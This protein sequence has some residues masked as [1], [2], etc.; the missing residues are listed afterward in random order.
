MGKQK[1][2]ASKAEIAARVAQIRA[3][4]DRDRVAHLGQTPRSGQPAPFSG[5][6][7]SRRS[8]HR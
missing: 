6:I 5:Q 3:K 1:K 2:T 8:G 7:R 4:S